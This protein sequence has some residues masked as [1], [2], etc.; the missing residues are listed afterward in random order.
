MLSG[1]VIGVELAGPVID[2][3]RSRSDARFEEHLICQSRLSH[4]TVADE[5]NVPNLL[6]FEF[7]HEIPFVE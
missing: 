2:G 7:R 6:R 5:N 4:S 1:F 3:A